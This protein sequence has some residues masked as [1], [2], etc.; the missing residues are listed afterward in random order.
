MKVRYVNQQDTRDCMNGAVISDDAKLVE[1]LESRRKQP[2]FF[3]RLLCDN[4]FELVLGIGGNVGCV[5]HSR[6]QGESTNLLAVSARPPLKRGYVE[7]LTA[8]TPTPVAARY[9]INFD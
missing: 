9:I 4:G 1:L 8:D 3:I 6:S 5:Q 2:P 7:F